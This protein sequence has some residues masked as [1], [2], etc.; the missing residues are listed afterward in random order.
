MRMN[1]LVLFSHFFPFFATPL[2]MLYNDTIRPFFPNSLVC[3]LL[4][5][6]FSI[7]SL[8]RN[9]LRNFPFLFLSIDSSSSAVVVVQPLKEISGISMPLSSL[10]C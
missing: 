6:K 1:L 3:V 8:L 2:K 7:L 10:S 4:C 5:H 9:H